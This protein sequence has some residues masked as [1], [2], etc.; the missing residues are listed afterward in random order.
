[1]RPPQ[2]IWSLCAFI[3]G[4]IGAN[5]VIL[6][7]IFYITGIPADGA[8]NWFFIPIGA[9]LFLLSVGLL[10]KCRFQKR[11][12][13]YL[14]AEGLAVVGKIQSVRHLVWIN[15]NTRTFANWPGQ[16]SPWVIQCS[17]C[18]G[19]RNYTVKSIL[20]WLK[21]STGFQRPVIYLDP[22]CPSHAYVDTDT[23]RWEL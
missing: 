15:W 21:P 4:L 23:I 9:F 16:R 19:G 5:F 20:S 12:I 6:G 1:M 7:L 2:T 10:I 18:Y 22:R 3:F 11:R 14:K 17:Y 13:E 8:P